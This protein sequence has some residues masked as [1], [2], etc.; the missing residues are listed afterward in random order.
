VTR[1]SPTLR[2]LALLAL[3][4]ALG[5]CAAI[6]AN[7]RVP[8]VVVAGSFAPARPP[9]V[10]LGAD[11]TRTCP[12][13]GH[14]SATYEQLARQVAEQGA[15]AAQADGQL[16]AVAEAFLGW[17]GD[18]PREA[19]RAFVARHYGLVS[20]TLQVVVNKLDSEDTRLVGEAV[21][22][23]IVQFANQVPTARYG[24]AADRIAKGKTL[25][26]IVLDSPRVA[27][28]PPLP[29]RLEPG[30]KAVLAGTLLGDLENPKVAISDAQG[31]VSEPPQ[32]PGKAFQAEL[33]CGQRPGRIVVE[34]SGE[35]MGNEALM[36]NLSVP[37][38]GPPLPTTVAV[39]PPPWP[40]AVAEQE[41]LLQKGID[42]ERAEGGL[43]PLTWSEPI[44]RIARSV[45]ESI[46]D[47]AAKGGVSVPVNIVQRLG[48]ADIQAPVILQNPAAGPTAEAASERLLQSPSHRANLMSTEVTTAGVGVALGNDKAGKPQA[49]LTQLFVKIQPPPDVP[50]AKQ[51]IREAIDRKRA[52]EK[53]G[54][55]A[56]DPALEKLASDYA[57]V[58]A[59]AGGPPPKART[60]ELV[61]ALRKG[62][63]DIVFLVDSR[64]DLA[65]F[66]EDPNALAGGKLVGLGAALG[67]H[68]RLGKNTLFVVLIIGNKLPGK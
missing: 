60:D 5:A 44:A 50:A 54:R 12:Q 2:R 45:S 19:V 26:I 11:P 57:A 66:A 31:V 13:G 39:A 15:A 7:R 14:Y 6:E 22:K 25:V 38:G 64:I 46:R 56:A 17:T 51:A 23:V 8:G 63:R 20:T 18:P 9:S 49:Y 68:P 35:E 33:S 10:R 67:R 58:V 62:Y 21:A 36:A 42:A 1:P 52:A 34:I 61:K 27:L 47:S 40:V 4:L 29:R 65:D 43:P 48:D 28:G 3:P 41:A 37:C 30:E 55:L 24:L 16:C 32:K 59:A 53:L